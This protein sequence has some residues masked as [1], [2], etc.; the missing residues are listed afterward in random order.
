MST[1]DSRL[2]GNDGAFQRRSYLLAASLRFAL[3]AASL[4]G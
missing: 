1:L 3:S 2:R 4:V